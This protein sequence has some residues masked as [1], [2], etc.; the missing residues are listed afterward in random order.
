MYRIPS[1]LAVIVL[2]IASGGRSEDPPTIDTRRG[3]H[4]G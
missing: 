4:C 2:G 3:A 1:L